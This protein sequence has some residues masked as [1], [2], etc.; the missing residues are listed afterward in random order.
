MADLV[1]YI[2]H[3]GYSD[4]DPVYVSWLNDIYYVSDK[5]EYAFKLATTAGGTT[6]VQ[7]TDEV[8]EGY[9]RKV[10]IASGV[11]DI[12]GLDHLEGDNVYVTSGG[13]VYGPYTVTSG[14]VTVPTLLFGYQVGLPYIMKARTMR[15]AVPMQDNTLQS[16]I[17]RIH[18]TVVRYVRSGSGEA[19]QEYGG[20]EYLSDLGTTYSDQSQDATILTTGGFSEDAYTIVVSKLPTPFTLLS[21]I[22]SFDIAESR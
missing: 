18:E 14:A 11:T 6:I 8:T 7:Y 22:V 13:E 21:T 16:R 2:P 3:H 10:D 12:T 5:D 19:G 15:L 4:D 17:K 20:T 1:I 9:V